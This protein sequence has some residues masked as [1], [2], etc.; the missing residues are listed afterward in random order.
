MAIVRSLVQAGL[1]GEKLLEALEAIDKE[2]PELKPI[3]QQLRPLMEQ[4]SEVYGIPV[5]DL[6]GTSRV[7]SIVEARH[8][9]YYL[10][11]TKTNYSTFRIAKIL[12]DVDHT[13]VLHG[14][15]KYASDNELSP[16]RGVNSWESET[17]FVEWYQAFPLHKEPLAAHRAYR[18][19]VNNAQ[20]TPE[21]LLAAAKRYRTECAG[22]DP[23]YI[24][25]PATW[26]NKGCWGD[27]PL[28]K[29]VDSVNNSPGVWISQDSPEWEEW[30]KYRNGN[31]LPVDKR[32]GWYVPSRFPNES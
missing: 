22:R 27:L 29:D 5:K 4:I 1:E 10:A 30:K 9:L 2:I 15:K 24:K 3:G 8:H 20:I 32:G 11:M 28:L 19:A 21:G 7:A 18:K 17:E 12:G 6:I 31:G 23:K 16:A 26:L 13:T 14:A 25:Y